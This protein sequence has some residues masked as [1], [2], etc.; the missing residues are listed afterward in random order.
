MNYFHRFVKLKSE[1]GCTCFPIRF[2]HPA[3]KPVNRYAG[4]ELA[5]I[6]IEKLR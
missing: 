5:I 2:Y 3:I 6:L 1:L 4:A